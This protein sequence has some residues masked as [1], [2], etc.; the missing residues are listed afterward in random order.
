MIPMYGTQ[1]DKDAGPGWI[2]TLA[3]RG[4]A[5]IAFACASMHGHAQPPQN[6][7]KQQPL[8]MQTLFERQCSA[9]HGGDGR[10]AERGP[11][12]ITARVAR[13]SDSQL[14]RLIRQGIP[15]GGMP[16][17]RLNDADVKALAAYVKSLAERRRPP[18]TFRRVRVLER[19]GRTLEGLALNESN[20]DLQLLTTEGGL[21]SLLRADLTEIVD[22]GRAAMPDLKP[23]D[24]ADNWAPGEW[25]MYN[26]DPGGN[27]HSMLRQITPAN[28]S[29]VRLKW[30]FPV[31]N[32]RNLKTTPVVVDGVMY[33][34][35][36]NE[37]Y[38]LDARSGRQIWHYSRPRTPGVI[39]D[40]GAGVNR[41]VAL[42]GDRLYFVTDD[43]RL[44]ALHRSNGQLLWEVTMAD[45]R[46]HYGGTTAPLVV[47]DLVISGVSGGDEG[48][49]GFLAAF[50]AV[51]GKEAWRYWT[52]PAPGAPGS[53]TWKGKAINYGCA[54]T[55]LTGSHDA[56]T[57]MLFWTTGNPC[58][59][60][61][62]DER[63]GDNVGSNSV[64]ALDPATGRLRWSY[65]FTPHDLN[66]WDAVQ[67]VIVA[68]TQFKGR[69]RS[70]LLQANRNG[71]FYVLDRATGKV[72]L[73]EPFVR[74]LTWAK[75]IGP[76]GRPER[77][78]G[79]EPSVRGTRICP[80][81]VGATNWMSPAF[82]P[83]TGL[84]YVMAL[85]ECSIFR[86]SAAWFEPGQSFY[87]GSTQSVSGEAGE[88]YLRA[89][90]IQTGRIAWEY[91][92]IGS[93]NSWGGLLSTVTGL[94]FFAEDSG[95]FAA[96]D[97]GNGKLLW[98]FPA[99]ATWR[100]SPMTYLAGGQ[101]FVA[102]AG[103]NTIFAF[104][105]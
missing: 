51:T 78:A 39:G 67:T 74:K 65:Q 15:A 42:R 36:P 99:N 43:A 87:G 35:A 28:V 95:A 13:Q 8:A 58:P 4:L 18:R 105:L 53:E 75:G 19:N 94:V 52:V 12:I 72:L 63:I 44:V 91:A 41:G 33:V 81:V 47:N 5:M 84:Y 79:A 83:D 55:W 34:T 9:C 10:G 70:L 20:F 2:W 98:H 62:G 40:A 7:G 21:A 31:E 6:T 76:D 92:Q 49:R 101:Q 102:I 85:E 69:V 24:I 104:G 26:G 38:A 54:A 32:S 96:V 93:G 29:Q 1:A 88:R 61:N 16:P 103:G 97:A 48:I 37:V 86:K 90:D 89:I 60:Y 17:S 30:L 11:D 100:A 46:K 71:F 22:L 27:R 77:I 25:P 64:L 68:D 56:Q 73:A 50:D 57:K 82:N 3:T 66:D 14:Q 80:S 23:R 59:D 45:H